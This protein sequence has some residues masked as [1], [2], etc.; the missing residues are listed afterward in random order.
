MIDLRTLL[1]AMVLTDLILAVSLWI[2]A[3]RGMRDGLGTWI[4]SLLVRASGVTIFALDGLAA[5]P[6]AIVLAVGLVAFS[7]TLQAAA[8]LAFGGRRLPTWVHSA[9]FAAVAMPFLLLSGDFGARVLFAGVAF[10]TMLAMLAGITLQLQAPISRGTR[11]LAIGS[12]AVASI[13][14]FLRAVGAVWSVDPL[15][16]FIEPNL[17]QTLT[18][19]GGFAALLASSSGVGL[20]H[21]ERADA[22][23]ARLATLDPLTGA[24]NRRSFHETAERE[25]AR[26]RRAAQPLSIII[27]DIDHFKAVNDKHGHK[28]GDEIIKTLADIVRAQLRKEDMLV[29]FGGEEFCVMLPQVPGPGAVVVAGR[30]RKAV[31]SDPVIIDGR[32][33]PLTVSLGV[34][35]RLD[36]GPESI[37]ELIARADQ[38]LAM[39]KERGRNRVVAL[40]LGRSIAA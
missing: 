13:L 25:L 19:A 11:G 12:F 7:M 15:M 1:L 36:E 20:M 21:K 40:S 27:L 24:Y 10:G 8:L 5:D 34:A 6:N 31:A 30:I 17:F 37:D 3:G 33:I 22:A 16:G 28:V 4:A 26:A 39:A 38:A 23:A 32:E 2:G 29:R 9:T 18:F 14:F 35:A